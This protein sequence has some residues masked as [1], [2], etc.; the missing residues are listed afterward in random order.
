M[1]S[2]WGKGSGRAILMIPGP[3]EMPPAV[4]EALNRP[5]IVN[6]DLRFNNTILEPVTLALR[7]VLQARESDALLLPG[8]G[9]TGL[10]AAI[11]SAVEPG[12]RVIAIVAG[13]FG[14]MMREILVRA[15]AEVT[16]V[17]VPW[18][19]P[20]DL[21]ALE[22]EIARVEPA[23]ITM[24]HNETTSGVVYPAAAVAAMARRAGALLLLDTVSS[25]GGIDI[26]VDTWGVDL[27]MS[28]SQKCLAGP[29]G[30]AI[31]CVGPRAWQRMERRRRRAPT[32][33]ND[34][35]RWR[36][37]WM[38]EERGGKVAPGVFRMQPVGVPSHL[39]GAMEVAVRLVLEEG[40][41]ARF[42]R[43]AGAA[44]A[45][46]AGAAAIGLP[47]LPDA[48]DASDTV[49]CFR[50]PAGIEPGRVV[51]IVHDRFGIQ[52]APGLGPLG[53]TTLRV[54]TMGITASPLYVLPTVAALEIA[55]QGLGVG[56]QAG[57]GVAAAQ[58]VFAEAN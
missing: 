16:E 52:I 40:L 3:T 44:R 1:V 45:L 57:V 54:A 9:R 12:D 50:V 22:Q 32:W 39:T 4:I 10:E 53:G 47:L 11:L 49:S 48:A 20:L 42:A 24:V 58:A 35:L 17:A 43:H 37:E 30:M 2:Q 55:L 28:A 7:E 51:Q 14:V 18:G 5:P 46:R 26:P 33:I 27:T 41:P 25:L 19:R 34:L 13:F 8:S 31:V 6:Y 23:A 21:D 38:L 56:V 36:D 29:A 15:G